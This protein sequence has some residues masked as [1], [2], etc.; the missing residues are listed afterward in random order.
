MWDTKEQNVNLSTLK[1]KAAIINGYL[2]LLFGSKLREKIIA[3][4]FHGN[5]YLFVDYLLTI[6]RNTQTVVG[7]RKS[8][9]ITMEPKSTC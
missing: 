3:V 5:F 2:L 1:I 9:Y 4:E 7:I 8:C 6:Y